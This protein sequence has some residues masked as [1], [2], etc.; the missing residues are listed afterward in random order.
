[1]TLGDLPILHRNSSDLE[2]LPRGLAKWDLSQKWYSCWREAVD[3]WQLVA[4][5][6]AAEC[7]PARLDAWARALT[8]TSIDDVLADD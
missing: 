4:A 1:L 3:G 6:I 5:R 7:D 8:A 2:R